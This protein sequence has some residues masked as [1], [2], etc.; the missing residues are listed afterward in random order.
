MKKNLLIKLFLTAVMTHFS[1]YCSEDKPLSIKDRWAKLLEANPYQ[2]QPI[3]PDQSSPVQP[4]PTAPQH[5]HAVQPA[6]AQN[7]PLEA[8][9]AKQDHEAWQ[10]LEQYLQSLTARFPF[11]NYQISEI[12]RLFMLAKRDCALKFYLIPQTKDDSYKKLR[13]A[14]DAFNNF[15]RAVDQGKEGVPN[16]IDPIEKY[17]AETH[18]YK[19]VLVP[20][21]TPPATQSG[22][23]CR[24][25]AK[26]FNSDH[27]LKRHMRNAHG[28]SITIHSKKHPKTLS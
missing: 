15:K 20:E 3:G 9:L 2:T 8:I 19:N 16:F 10:K 28:E 22:T 12:M 7:L 26:A 24:Y 27:M 25:C 21:N 14:I 17:L 13:E 18:Y 23:A 4:I 6:K 11:N 5:I 1:L